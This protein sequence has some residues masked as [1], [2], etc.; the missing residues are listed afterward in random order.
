MISIQFTVH[1]HLQI[2]EHKF[3]NK[4]EIKEMKMKIKP[5]FDSSLVDKSLDQSL[6]TRIQI[7]NSVL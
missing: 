1:F 3:A 7:N 2:V 4:Y 5:K 6:F